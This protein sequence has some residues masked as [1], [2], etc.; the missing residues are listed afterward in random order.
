MTAEPEIVRLTPATPHVRFF[1]LEDVKRWL[2]KVIDATLDELQPAEALKLVEWMRDDA[3]ARYLEMD[4]S[5]G[6]P[7]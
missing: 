2:G 3:A 1:D 7:P 5:D 4:P 6:W